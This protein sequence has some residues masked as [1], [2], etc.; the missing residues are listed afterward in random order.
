ML[1]PGNRMT[2]TKNK[3]KGSPALSFL[4]RKLTDMLY[5]LVGRHIFAAQ[6]RGNGFAPK[7]A[8]A[9]LGIDEMQTKGQIQSHHERSVPFL[10]SKV[11][12]K[13][14]TKQIPDIAQHKSAGADTNWWK[15][16]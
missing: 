16:Y 4:K 13:I 6:S 2:H 14:S 1:Q 11:R 5:Q 12:A 7:L 8:V 15:C 3:A 9:L 10:Q